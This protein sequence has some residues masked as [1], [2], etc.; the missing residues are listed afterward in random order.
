MATL[1]QEQLA[2]ILFGIR[3]YVDNPKNPHVLDRRQMPWHGM[4]QKMKKTVPFINNKITVKYKSEA[5]DLD[6]Q[7][8][9]GKDRLGFQEFRTGFDLTF[10]GVQ[11][12]MGLEFEHQELKDQGYLIVPNGPRSQNFAGKMS[13]VEALRIFDT[14]KEKFESAYDRWDILIDQKFL[15]NVSGNSSEPV[16]LT[17]LV[18][19][20][21]TVGQFGNRDRSDAQMQ[22]SATL[23]S[24]ATT[25]ER[26]MNLLFRQC[27][28]Y[29]RGF[30][31]AGVNAIMASGGWIDRYS[32]AM[33]DSTN[34]FR[35]NTDIKNPGPVDLGIPDTAWAY[36]G[37][38]VVYN[39]TMELMAQLTGDATWNRRAYLLNTQSFTWGCGEKEDKLVTFPNDPHDQRITRGSIDGR[40]SMYCINPRTNAVHEFAA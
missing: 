33:R 39:P 29:N 23:N 17:D 3:E 30:K 37:V 16:A 1:T 10:S 28:L 18:S 20:T 5:D 11:L 7:T 35:M 25:F 19:K 31:G 8:W 38:P 27:M 14:L 24:T 12:H 6:M 34:G 40:Y 9:Y 2:E 4:L 22:N 26:D 21:P 15:H 32:A 13:R 36:A